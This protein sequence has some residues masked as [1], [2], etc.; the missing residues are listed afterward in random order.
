[1]NSITSGLQIG[2]RT[3][4]GSQPG[5]NQVCH[6]SKTPKSHDARRNSI[7][8]AVNA[9]LSSN[10]ARPN[11]HQRSHTTKTR[12]GRAGRTEEARAAIA[13][14]KRVAPDITIETTRQQLPL[15]DPANMERYLDRLRKAGLG[16]PDE[17]S[18]LK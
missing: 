15:E 1:M 4:P 10:P 13:E 6:R 3:Q 14:L 2:G 16:I 12:S 7:I 17:P 5:D 11:S 8:A 9:R 18:T